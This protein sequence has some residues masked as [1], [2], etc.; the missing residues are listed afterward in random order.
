MVHDRSRTAR[1]HRNG[2]PRPCT[3]SAREP[4]PRRTAHAARRVMCPVPAPHPAP[5]RHAGRASA[6]LAHALRYLLADAVKAHAYPT[7]QG[8][9]DETS[10]SVEVRFDGRRACARGQEPVRARGRC[11]HRPDQGRHPALAVGHDGDLG[12]VAEGHRA[13][14][15]RRHQQERRRDGPQAR[16]RGGRSRVELA[17]VRREGAPAA[18][19]GQGRVRVRLRC[20]R[21]SRS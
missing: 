12:D 3:I 8:E 11:G 6:R 17:A 21:C 7:R 16:A 20:C 1:R 19:A 5:R 15:D 18:H 2:E 14:D 4:A 10:Q 9:P 13:D